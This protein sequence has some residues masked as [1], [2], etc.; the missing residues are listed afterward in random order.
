MG[1]ELD[2]F[3]TAATVYFGMTYNN[4]KFL[5]ITIL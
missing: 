2:I 5:A 1:R 4:S 3:Y